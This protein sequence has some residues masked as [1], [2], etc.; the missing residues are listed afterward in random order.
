MRLVLAL[1]LAQSCTGAPAFAQVPETTVVKTADKF[2]EYG[3]S[4]AVI[5]LLIGVAYFLARHLIEC[6][7]TNAAGAATTAA[8]VTANTATGEKIADALQEVSRRLETVER[9]IERRAS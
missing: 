2:L 5:V 3:L 1:A 7:K 6:H 8:A 9:A 4:G